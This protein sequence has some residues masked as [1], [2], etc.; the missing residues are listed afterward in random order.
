MVGGT[1][2]GGTPLAE[3]WVADL[4]NVGTTLLVN[5]TRADIEGS[6]TPRYDS[7][8]VNFGGRLTLT[9]GLHS[10]CTLPAQSFL[11]LAL[12]PFALLSA[13]CL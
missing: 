11:L 10:H 8:L 6:L 7:S 3:A 4:S 9:A 2:E 1:I 12:P 13:S 5:W